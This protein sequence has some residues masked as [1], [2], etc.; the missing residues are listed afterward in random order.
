MNN[1]YD[2]A[3]QHIKVTDEMQARIRK[4]LNNLDVEKVPNP[5]LPLSNYKKYMSIAACFVF[6]LVGSMILHNVI[7]TPSQPPVQVAPNVVS[8]QSV[9]ELSDAVGFTVKELQKLPFDVES[10]KY[11]SFWDEL[12]DIEYVGAEN[13]AIFRMAAG[14]EDI[15]GYHDEFTTVESRVVNGY[16]V[17]MKGYGNQYSIAIWSYDGSSYAL[18]FDEPVLEQEMLDTLQHIA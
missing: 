4:N 15:S 9:G 7:H 11:T 2:K 12:A 6:L 1:R 3:M 13:T 8:Y 18:R 5:V 10:I 14:N 16:D 17:V